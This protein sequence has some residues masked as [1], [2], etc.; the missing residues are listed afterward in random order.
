M[1]RIIYIVPLLLAMFSLSS[2]HVGAYLDKGQRVLLSNQIKVS[3]ADSSD[4]GSEINEALVNSQQYY[5]QKPNKKILFVPVM[6]HLYCSTNPSDTSKWAKFWRKTGEAPV[7]YDPKASARTANQ[8]SALMKTKGC[9]NNQV[10]TDTIN[11]GK[12]FVKVIYNVTTSQRR[13][14]DEL[15]FRSRQNDINTLLQSWKEES[16]LKVGDYYDQKKMTQEQTR[17][18]NLLKNEGYYQ[19]SADLVHFYV[20]TTYDSQRLSILVTIRAQEKNDTTSKRQ[21]ATLQK[22]HI[23]NIYIYPNISTDL[24][25]PRHAFD[26]LVYDYNNRR[27]KTKYNFIYDKEITPKPKTISRSMFIFNGMTYR[28]RMISNTSNALFGLHNFKFVDIRFEESPNS[29]DSNRLL[30][31]KIRLLNNTKHRLSLSFE[32]TNS[33]DIGNTEGNLFTSGNLGLGTT[34]GYRNSNLFGGAEM[35][36]IEGNLIFDFPKNVFTNE[37]LT[38]RNTFSNF[39]SG[40]SF[41]LDLPSFLLPFSNYI[42]W[43][44]NKP[45]TIFEFNV[46]YLFRA[47]SIPDFSTGAIDDVNLE[48][49]RLGGSFG[50][51]WNHNTNEQHK[52]L[53]INISYSRLLSGS[54]YYDYLVQMTSDPQFSYQAVDYVL[55]NTHYEYTFSGQKIGSRENFNFLRISVETAGNILNG[56]DKL[57]NKENSTNGITYYQYARLESEFKRY[58]YLGEKS[59]LVLR[60]LGGMCI[61]YGHSTFIP[62]EKMFIGGGP[63]TMRGWAL[64]HLGAGQTLT[65]E[66]NFALGTGEVQLVVNVEHRFPIIGIFEGAVFTDI[67]NVWSYHEWGNSENN[68]FRIRNIVDGLGFDAG[69]GLRINISI[70]T[71]RADLALPLYDPGYHPGER[72]LTDHWSW[73]KMVLNFGIN[74]PF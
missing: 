23:D 31:A 46:N 37:E 70:I 29:S 41:S 6:M 39:E 16:L 38:F 9:F 52:L 19:A 50:Y 5:Y 20:D 47:L 58:F 65:S 24:S 36:N 64:R 45:H 42:I 71:V 7:I 63:T 53:P 26:T 68:R 40:V 15:N 44:N 4:V 43:Q 2:C 34:L 48:R 32:L 74:Y 60:G 10:S 11:D 30:D 69:L 35:L 13:R 14:I 54:R 22:Y 72:W 12:Y 3:M 49:R 51:T 61:P 66:T 18:V 27:G 67:G 25:A 1:K 8:L 56:I 62:Y 28:P 59:T 73:K 21:Y 55:F 33:S 57:F 17:L